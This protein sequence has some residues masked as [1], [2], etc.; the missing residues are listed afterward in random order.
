VDYPFSKV[1][2]KSSNE[3]ASAFVYVHVQS[4]FWSIDEA[5]LTTAVQQW[6]LENVPEVVA[7]TAERREQIFPTTQL[8]SLP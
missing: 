2:A 8:P 7:T 4:E 1:T 3:D 5:G 6:L